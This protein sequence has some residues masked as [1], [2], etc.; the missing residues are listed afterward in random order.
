M[1]PL[2][3]LGVIGRDVRRRMTE[4]LLF[5]R[6]AG[7][8]FN[9]YGYTYNRTHLYGLCRRLQDVAQV[10]W[11]MTC[12]FGVC[13]RAQRRLFTPLTSHVNSDVLFL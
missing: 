5:D 13:R 10:S 12:M 2:L 1:V 7:E 8:M 9:D 11:C 3:I 4:Y 6:R